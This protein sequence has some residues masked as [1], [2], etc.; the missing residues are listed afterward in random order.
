MLAI[1]FALSDPR[2]ATQTEFRTL[3][4]E[5][6]ADVKSAIPTKF[7]VT[8]TM[9]NHYAAPLA[10]MG[11]GE[12]GFLNFKVLSG[13]KVMMQ[14]TYD[15]LPPERSSF[16]PLKD[17]ASQ[18]YSENL[19]KL[20]VIPKATTRVQVWYEY[21][22]MFVENGVCWM[23]GGGKSNAITLRLSPSKITVEE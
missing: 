3:S 10:V 11:L 1:L 17:G 9:R 16:F 14:R 22:P 12:G 13:S 18:S 23:M 5:L 20:W 15:S 6:K 7:T 19:G 4:F 2:L 8:V 21:S